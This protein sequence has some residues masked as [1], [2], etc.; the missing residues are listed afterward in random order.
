MSDLAARSL[1][2]V[3]HPC[4]RMKRAQNSPPLAIARG[5]GPWLFDTQGRRYFDAISSWWVNLFGHADPTLNAALK[6]QLDTLPHVMLAGCTQESAVQ[7]AEKLSARTGGVLGHAFYGSDGASAVE[8]ALK[9][10]FH[11]WR[12][13]GQSQKRE[14]VCLKN[15]YHGETLG[16]LSVTDVAIFRDAY[17]PLLMRAH[18]VMSPD[19]RQAGPDETAE[20]L[21]QRALQALDDLLQ[22][23]Q[24]Q[25]AALI[26]EPLIQC[27]AGMAMHQ[28]SYLRG[29]HGLCQQWGVHLIA[30]EIAVGCGRT[31][32]FF[33]FEQATLP[34]QQPL[35]PDFI[36]LSKGIT[37]GYLPLSVVLAR[38]EIYQAFWFDDA[39][40][41]FLHSHSYSGN[42]LACRAAWAVLDRFERDDVLARNVQL[43]APLSQAWNALQGDQ[44]LCHVRQQGM[45]WAFDVKAEIPDFSERFHQAA[46]SRELL[47]RPIGQTVYLMPPYLLKP[48]DYAWLAEQTL[49]TLQDVLNA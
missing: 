48:D 4:T 14:F 29:V 45:V 22:A 46:R 1:R 17:D 31:G 40:R 37:G 30:D 28:A 26:I 3:W 2:S 10:S 12:N 41:S 42:A 20:Q 34:G 39:A 44:R 11:A 36:T 47:I 35:W 32:T 7:V 24:G 33:A 38:D 5:E 6:D 13:Q 23:R 21:T 15:G 25:V 49:A 27:A 8:I 18:T 9:M 19:L 43:S 16:A